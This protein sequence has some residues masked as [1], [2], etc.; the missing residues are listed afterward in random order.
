[1]NPSSPIQIVFSIP[2]KC[3]VTI[4]LFVRNHFVHFVLCLMNLNILLNPWTR[5]QFVPSLPPSSL[6]PSISLSIS[7]NVNCQIETCT[8]SLQQ[9]YKKI[10]LQG[11]V[12]RRCFDTMKL[13]LRR[14]HNEINRGCITHYL[15]LNVNRQIVH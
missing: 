3:S 13:G 9:L 4:A 7:I 5:N 6:S 1:M 2:P 14:E 8:K 11:S 15:H 12:L 10:D